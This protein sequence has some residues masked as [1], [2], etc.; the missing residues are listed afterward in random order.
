M[1]EH[2]RHLPCIYCTVGFPCYSI[3]P[4]THKRYTNMDTVLYIHIYMIKYYVYNHIYMCVCVCM[5][6]KTV[7]A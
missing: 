7:L 4:A 1:E 6:L 3:S 2:R 5:W